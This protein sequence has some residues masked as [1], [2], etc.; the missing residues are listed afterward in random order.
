MQVETEAWQEGS[1]SAKNCL[2]LEAPSFA[3]TRLKRPCIAPGPSG[4]V[5]AWALLQAKFLRRDFLILNLFKYQVK[6]NPRTSDILHPDGDILVKG[7][8]VLTPKGFEEARWC[9]DLIE[10]WIATGT[11]RKILVAAGAP[12]LN[13]VTGLVGISKWRGSPFPPTPQRGCW[14]IPTIH[15]AACLERGEDAGAY[16]QR[17]TLV[18]DFEKTK[19]FASGYTPPTRRLI[20][21]PKF[22]QVTSFFDTLDQKPA[23][24][25]DLEI[26]KTME[27][28]TCFSLAYSALDSICI[29]VVNEKGQPW[30]SEN[31]ELLIW[32]RFAKL[33]TSGKKIINQN[34]IFDLS[35][36]LQSLGLHFRGKLCDTMIG[37]NILLPDFPKGLDFITSILTDEVYYKDDGKVWKTEGRNSLFRDPMKF[38]RYNALD[39]AVAFEAWDG[40]SWHPGLE[41]SLVNGNYWTTYLRDI[42]KFGPLLDMMARGLEVDSEE[43]QRVSSATDLLISEKTKKF[44]ELCGFPIKPSS[45]AACQRYF[46]DTLALNPYTSRKSGN[47]T[48]DKKALSR[49]ARRTGKGAAEAQLLQDLR[50]LMKFRDSYGDIT[51]D[52]DGRVRCSWAPRGTIMGRLSS[53]QTIFGRGLNMQNLTPSFKTFLVAGKDETRKNW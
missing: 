7:S 8:K 39:S 24:A 3:E 41:T 40:N 45:N 52:A 20:I 28:V 25:V 17:L 42:R 46:Y 36:F 19:R 13:A 6:K 12:A 51:W 16:H 1:L 31:D 32:Q 2:L 11:D 47:T 49:I 27:Q 23:F 21:D 10:Q 9:L 4:E 26:A 30:W 50:Q 18:N 37:F 53:S 14:V 5:L 34:L 48:L 38:F 35:I 43:L 22:E 33:L 29:P 15:P 44:Q